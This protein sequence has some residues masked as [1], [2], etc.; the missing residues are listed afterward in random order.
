MASSLAYNSFP[1]LHAL[2][3]GDQSRNL[4]GWLLDI[5]IATPDGLNILNTNN[6]HYYGT[7]LSSVYA[8]ADSG[9]DTSITDPW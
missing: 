7:V 4:P 9:F 2:V 1:P 6:Q 5:D 8:K 3:L